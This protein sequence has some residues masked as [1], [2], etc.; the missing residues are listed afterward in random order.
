MKERHTVTAGPAKRFQRSSVVM[1]QMALVMTGLIASIALPAILHSQ[2]KKPQQTA[3][4]GVRVAMH[5][6]KY[7][8]AENVSVQINE[9]KGAIVP[10]GSDQMPVFDDKDSFKVHIDAAEVAISPQ[11]VANLLN[12]FVFSRPGSQ[13]SGISVATNTQHGKHEGHLKIKGRLKDKGDIPFELEGA[14]IPTPDGKLRLHADKMKALK[15]P[16]SGLME[17]F[18]VEVDN[19][20]KS[21]KVPGV[22]AQE[23]DLIFDL[24]RMLPSPQIEGKVTKV[25]VEPNTI[26]YTI[27]SDPSSGRDESA[28]NRKAMPKLRGNYMSFRGN[29]MEVGKFAMEDCDIVMMDMDPSDPMDFFLDRYKEQLAAGYLKIATSSQVRAYIKDYGKLAAGKNAAAAAPVT[30]PA[31]KK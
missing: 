23:N 5:N 7:R 21:G 30:E 24:E 27:A 22:D 14:L 18:G 15:I 17:A 12:Q 9:L 13:L 16:I 20:I 26:V 4:R 31:A 10:I 19:L 11:D 28:D 6:V 1:A 25:R 2:E 8:F 3:D 29:R